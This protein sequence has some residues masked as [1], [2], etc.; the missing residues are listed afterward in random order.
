MLTY[1]KVTAESWTQ[2]GNESEPDP[3]LLQLILEK[4][5]QLLSEFL[6]TRPDVEGLDLF[7]LKLNTVLIL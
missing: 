5:I 1:V 6:F 7:I 2:L 3:V 4:R